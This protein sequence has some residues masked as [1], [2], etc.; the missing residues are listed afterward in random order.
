MAPMSVLWES[1]SLPISSDGYA[2]SVV[3]H[4]P[5][6]C[7]CMS[8]SFACARSQS[9]IGMRPKPNTRKE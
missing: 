7:A 1:R 5:I 8:D 6:C 3:I 9:T 4:S 2:P